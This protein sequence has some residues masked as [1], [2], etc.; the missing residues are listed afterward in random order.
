MGSPSM[1]ASS[2]SF[3]LITPAVLVMLSGL[4]CAVW[5]VWR[6]Q[7]ALVLAGALLLLSAGLLVQALLRP[8]HAILPLWYVWSFSACYLTA[9]VCTAW[10]VAQRLQVALFRKCAV[11]LWLAAMVWQAWFTVADYN[12]SARIYGLSG[13]ALAIFVLPL[14]QWQKMLPSNRYDHVLRWACVVFALV[15]WGRTVLQLPVSLDNPVQQYTQTT[16]WVGLHL[17][18][19]VAGCSLAVLLL[20]A[21]LHDVLHSL[22]EERQQDPLTRLLNRRGF[23]EGVLH[24][25]ALGTTHGWGLL[26]VDLDHFKGVNDSWGHLAG[27]QVLQNVAQGL[28]RY[29]A[30]GSLLARFG[31]EEFVLLMAGITQAQALGLAEKIRADIAQVAQP[32]MQGLHVTA[33]IGVAMLPVLSQP[34]LAHALLLADVQLY[35]AK[36]AGRNC[37]AA[38]VPTAPVPCSI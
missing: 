17:F 25:I 14:L 13:A 20:L 30:P 38:S 6:S 26:V 22:N 4:L 5:R 29:V 21:V 18:F 16:F 1:I 34:Q 10:A 7:S 23:D 37:V 27:D 8:V 12:M 35:E 31:G 2:T 3:A 15:H 33:S 32:A 24:A 36:R 9:T 28:Q 19:V 11:V